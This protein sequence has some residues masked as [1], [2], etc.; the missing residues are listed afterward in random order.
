MSSM[1]NV[2]FEATIH[3][4]QDMVS[5][6]DLSN[7][8]T[9]CLQTTIT[10]G[11]VVSSIKVLDY[12]SEFTAPIVYASRDQQP[13]DSQKNDNQENISRRIHSSLN[14][15]RSYHGSNGVKPSDNK[16]TTTIVP[17][18]TE[19]VSEAKEPI[20]ESVKEVEPAII[21]GAFTTF[22][23]IDAL[24]RVKAISLWLDEAR[25]IMEE[26][27]KIRN[28]IKDITENLLAGLQNG[29]NGN[30]HPGQ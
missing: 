4:V 26:V 15:G 21:N 19:S 3:D 24:S 12:C 18:P 8:L 14:V 29:Q 22:D 5:A 6:D 28:E 16:S 13:N 27:P 25:G 2:I 1:I 23:I 7:K 11:V 20:P 30:T 9:E 10:G 17:E